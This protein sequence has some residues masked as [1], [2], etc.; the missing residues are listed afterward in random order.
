[1]LI[2]FQIFTKFFLAK[3]T[4]G[5]IT[6]NDCMILQ[7]N[8]REF[9]EHLILKKV[10][11]RKKLIFRF[12]ILL[13]IFHPLFHNITSHII[14]IYFYTFDK[15]TSP[16]TYSTVCTELNSSLQIGLNQLIYF[17]IMYREYVLDKKK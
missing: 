10:L 11:I 5:E 12:S 3:S 9:M 8:W 13:M 16:C 15:I 1:M 6:K 14:Y 17:L 2:Q 4:K 7:T